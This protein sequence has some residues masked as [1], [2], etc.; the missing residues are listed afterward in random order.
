MKMQI[1]QY[2]LSGY[3]KRATCCSCFTLHQQFVHLTHFIHPHTKQ[4]WGHKAHNGRIPGGHQGNGPEKGL[5]TLRKK[6]EEPL[7]ASG[8]GISS[9]GLPLAMLAS[10][11][12]IPRELRR[13]EEKQKWAFTEQPPN[14]AKAPDTERLG[15]LPK[16]M[17]LT[18]WYAGA[19]IWTQEVWLQGQSY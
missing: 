15:D 11:N 1:I 16:V 12:S 10:A 14:L 18:R 9:A 3:K 5:K 19:G 4:Q 17:K 6:M 13:R 7:E 8:T 2:A